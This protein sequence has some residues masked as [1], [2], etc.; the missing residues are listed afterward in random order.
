MY[1]PKP[2]T[3]FNRRNFVFRCLYIDDISILFENRDG[4]RG[5]DTSGDD[6]Q[7]AGGWPDDIEVE[8]WD[9]AAQAF[10]PCIRCAGEERVRVDYH[11]DL[12]NLNVYEV[13]RSEDGKE[14][15]VVDGRSALH[16]QIDLS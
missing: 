10:F 11:G 5:L 2:G 9:R 8:V 4:E 16:W 15:R 1:Q 14:F 12:G 6:F 13:I 3:F 7:P